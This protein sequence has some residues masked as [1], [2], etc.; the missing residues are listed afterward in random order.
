MIVPVLIV[1]LLRSDAGTRD[2]SC[3]FLVYY[4]DDTNHKFCSREKPEIEPLATI[5]NGA[6]MN[7]TE[8]K[9]TADLVGDFYQMQ[10]TNERDTR[11]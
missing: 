9:S 5:A 6:T 11:H 7:A 1:I 2:A 3:G 4:A 8:K 10:P